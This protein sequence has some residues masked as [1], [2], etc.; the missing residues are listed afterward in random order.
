[1]RNL[2]I[3]NGINIKYAKEYYKPAAI[4][5]RFRSVLLASS[6]LYQALFSFPI[7][8]RILEDFDKLP[9]NAN[10]EVLAESVYNQLKT[11][12]CLNGAKDNLDHR[13]VSAL[14]TSAL[15]AIFFDHEKKLSVII[16]SEDVKILKSFD[17]AFT[18]NYYEFWNPAD[19]Q[20]RYLHGSIQKQLSMIPDNSTKPVLLF[21]QSRYNA[22][23][24]KPSENLYFEKV[25]ELK[26]EYEL[27]PIIEGDF[28]FSPSHID[29]LYISSLH[30]SP[31]LYIGW[32]LILPPDHSK[33]YEEIKN[34][35]SLFVFGVSPFGDDKLISAI[36]KIS[37][38]TV[39]IHDIK[40]NTN[41]LSAWKSQ[42]NHTTAEYK[43]SDEFWKLP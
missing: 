32:D 2:L 18:L 15:T 28:L 35:D 31:K 20:C 4:R 17:Q 42:L 13:I 19:E 24:E 41:E 21:D 12:A 26:K 5:M 36:N 40:S 11:N 29:K 25:D 1:M 8:E 14:K 27:Y 3:G 34:L 39:F 9:E 23:K 16:P 10:I 22:S 30:L 7:D 43:D 37:K 38:V 33:A 6:I